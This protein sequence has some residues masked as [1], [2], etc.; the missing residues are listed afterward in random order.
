MDAVAESKRLKDIANNI[1]NDFKYVAQLL[2]P[3]LHSLTLPINI[4]LQKA[5][6]RQQQVATLLSNFS[7]LD[8][9]QMVD[10]SAVVVPFGHPAV[11]QL[12]LHVLWKDNYSTYL[13]DNANINMVVTF[14]DTIIHWI[15]QDHG[16][17]SVSQS[18]FNTCENTSE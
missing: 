18:E 15:L 16:N 2:V 9:I 5:M 11:V 7:Y 6:L 14:A 3:Q 10:G 17:I 12:I 1:H 4:W 13:P 8:D